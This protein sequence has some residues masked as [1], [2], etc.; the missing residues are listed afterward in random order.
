MNPL[1]PVSRWVCLQ[2]NLLD[3]IALLC[4]RASTYSQFVIF[5]LISIFQNCLSL[6]RVVTGRV[7][8]IKFAVKYQISC[9][10]VGQN[11]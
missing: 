2:E 3:I 7:K 8:M 6:T 10:R 1:F 4:I 9:T 5:S 11:Y